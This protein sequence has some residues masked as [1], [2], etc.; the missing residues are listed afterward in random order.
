[1][2]VHTK[3][4]LIERVIGDFFQHRTRFRVVFCKSVCKH[5]NG[6]AKL[7]NNIVLFVRIDDE[8]WNR[9]TIAAVPVKTSYSKIF[10]PLTIRSW[11]FGSILGSEMENDNR[12]FV[13]GLI[14]SGDQ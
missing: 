2:T 7:S 3:C 5:D 1:M 11:L 12:V 9:E 4:S 6:D 13:L 14:S 10:S 8:V